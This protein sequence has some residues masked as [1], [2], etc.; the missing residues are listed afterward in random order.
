MTSL[1]IVNKNLEHKIKCAKLFENKME[2]NEF[3]NALL[4]EIDELQQIK[5]DL[6]VLEI[7]R[8][9]KVDMEYLNNLITIKP[10]LSET[11]LLDKYNY[12]QKIE[13]RLTLEELLKLKQWL[14]KN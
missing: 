12:L 5:Q 14:E 3:L 13:L 9:K 1:E 6:E 11:K 7:I 10:K 2:S 4:D 8:K